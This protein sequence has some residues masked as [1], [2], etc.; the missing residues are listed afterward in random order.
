MAGK[1]ISAND[2]AKK[3]GYTHSYIRNVISGT[4][5]SRKARRAIE[6]VLG[7]PVWSNLETS[8]ASEESKNG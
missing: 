8:T 6:E 7:A 4:F 3:T 2:I 1:D 5:T